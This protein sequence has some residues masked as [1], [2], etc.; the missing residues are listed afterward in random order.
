[1][2]A[3]IAHGMMACMVH[4]AILFGG[5]SCEHEVSCVSAK[6]VLNH[7]SSHHDALLIGIGKNGAWYRQNL[8]SEASDALKVVPD[9]ANQLSI[10][11]SGGIVNAMG[12][13]IPLDVVIPVLHGSYGE[14]GRV[15]GLLEIAR[16]AYAGSGVLGSAVGMDKEI[17]RK[18]WQQEGL[19][20][21]PYRTLRVGTD[22]LED[23]KLPDKL[24]AELG[25]PLFVK[26][27][28][29]GS[30]IGVSRVI[31]RSEM[32][33]AL[34]TAAIYDRKILVEKGVIG[35]EIECAV[36]GYTQPEA[37]V[38]GEIVPIGQ[39]LFYDYDA[40][41]ID[42]NGALLHVPADLSESILQS[43]QDIAVLAYR[44]V[45]AGGLARV[46]FLVDRKT[47][48]LLLN[49]INTMPGMTPISLFPRMTAHGGLDFTAVIDRLVQGAL[50][51]FAYREALSY[52]HS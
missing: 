20:V 48:E 41:Y 26:P 47:D 37:F 22:R 8:P 43:I 15:Q 35:R 25:N 4:V 21:V 7:L 40:K 6:S 14:D 46:D 2:F 19:P 36:M 11:P 1:M 3:W 28:N 27:A 51:E 33:E 29:A 16:V 13:K 44:A 10:Q 18:I 42:P 5:R 49:E 12:E 17:A 23:A 9:K 24:F 31:N 52:S 50:E 39:H 34:K 32:I 30:S 45:D 38:P